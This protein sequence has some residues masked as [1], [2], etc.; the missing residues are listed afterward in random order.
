[1]FLFSSAS[2]FMLVCILQVAAVDYHAP[3]AMREADASVVTQMSS[4]QL[5]NLAPY[6]QFARAAYCPPKTV[7]DWKCGR[8]Q[9]HFLFGLC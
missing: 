3:P 2:S 4:S 7:I 1:M 5:A 8:T 9:S 6:T